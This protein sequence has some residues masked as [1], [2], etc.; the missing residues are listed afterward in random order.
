MISGKVFEFLYSGKIVFEVGGISSLGERIKK[1]GGKKVF[2]SIDKGILNS[3]SIAEGIA[4]IEKE[5]LQYTIFSDIEPNPS[6][7]IAEKGSR[8]FLE[9]QCDFLVGIGGGSSI[10]TAKAIGILTTNPGPLT[11]YEG[12]DKVSNPVPAIIA[13]PTTAGTGTEVTGST[14]L[15]DPVRKYKLSIRSDFLLPRI[16]LLDPSLLCSLPTAV[17]AST[18]MDAL[19]HAIESFISVGAS[20]ISDGLAL[21]AIRLCGE[22]LRNFYANPDNLEAASNMMLASTLAG[23]SFANARLGCIHAIAHALGGY[24]NI[25]HGVACAVLLPFGMEY[26]LIAN[27]EKFARIA[28]AMGEKIDGLGQMNAA[29]RSVDAVRS[30]LKDLGIPET[31][32][33]QGVKSEDIPQVSRNAAETGIHFSSPRKTG[34]KE[35]ESILMTAL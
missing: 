12:P 11:Q 13:I 32:T 9:N 10:D 26:N 33:E 7:E 19:V 27:P 28:S 8:I 22:N 18:G 3:K 6:I 24:Y 34:L 29:R 23:V 35:L 4:S 21:E 5:G 20:P 31:L 14:V 15:T 25:A 30:L 2:I 1:L 17:I 16:A